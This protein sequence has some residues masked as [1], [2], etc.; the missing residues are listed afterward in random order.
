MDFTDVPSPAEPLS[1]FIFSRKHFSPEY[2]RVKADAFL[3]EP[4]ALETS[5]FRLLGLD[6][7]QIQGIASAVAHASGRQFKA[8]GDVLAGTVFTVGLAVRPDNTPERHASI[9]GWP[10]D[11]G[12]QLS[13]A[14]R[15]AAAAT[16]HI[17][18]PATQS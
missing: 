15:I 11:K 7:A 18:N 12:Q 17:A 3:P 2:K 8:R 5:V 10:N 14:Q 13:L 4:T 1:R 16:L 9:V 6:A